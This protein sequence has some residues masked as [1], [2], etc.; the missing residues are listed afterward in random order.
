MVRGLYTSVSGMTARMIEMDVVSNNLANVNTTAYKRDEVICKAF[1]EMLLRRV[2]DDGVRSFPP[3]SYDVRPVVGKLGTG[4]EIN[5]SYTR[6]DQ[7]SLRQTENPLDIAFKKSEQFFVIQTPQGEKFTRNG[8]FALDE[9]S[10]L[11]TK[12]GYYLLGQEGPL[13]IKH[14]NF[15]I[16]DQG[17]IFINRQLQDPLTRPVQTNEGARGTEQE[18]LDSIRVVEFP[19]VRFLQKVG[20]MFF[21]E[22]EDSGPPQPVDSGKIAMVQGFLEMANVNV[23][24]EM[25]KMIEVQR[26]YESSQKGVITH[27]ATLEKL[28][29]QVATVA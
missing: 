4:V 27:D 17:K 14:N 6:Q 11:V 28:V 25:V 24:N 5:E 20:H 8:S 3:G 13:Q 1:P 18:V 16:D 15:F 21:E 26:S 29:N 22:T 23:V 9:N 12:Q 7:A 2:D 19:Q 10:F